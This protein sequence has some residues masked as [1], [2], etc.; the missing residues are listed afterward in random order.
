MVAAEK[1]E[2][3]IE[4]IKLADGLI[5]GLYTVTTANTDDWIVVEHAEATR[6]GMAF[7]TA[8]GTDQEAFN[9]T[10]ILKL[11]VSGIATVLSVFDSV[12]ST[13]GAT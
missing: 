2:T 9:S 10:N 11:N 7:T 1:T 6:F 13:G 5:I 4:E 8:D 3:L 12:K